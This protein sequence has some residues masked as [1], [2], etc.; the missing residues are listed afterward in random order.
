[1]FLNRCT[2][3]SK[4]ECGQ[5]GKRHNKEQYKLGIGYLWNY[6]SECSAPREIPTIARRILDAIVWCARLE[7]G[8][9]FC[10]S[11]PRFRHVALSR[12]FSKI[13]FPLFGI[14]L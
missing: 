4:L 7:R 11:S 2:A 10:E 12:I 14:M 6:L 9:F 13:R 5:T 3:A 1:L 8:D